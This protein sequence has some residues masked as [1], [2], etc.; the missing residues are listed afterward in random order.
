MFG[1]GRDSNDDYLV[2][3]EI[4]ARINQLDILQYYL[5]YSTLPV[6]ISSP[7]RPDK[8][9]SFGLFLNNY[10]GVSYKDH[11]TFD[12][13]DLF[14]L[15]GKIW[16]IP[17]K[18]VLK[19][20]TQDIPEIKKLGSPLIINKFGAS[21]R[22]KS[23]LHPD[24]D[25]KVKVREWKQHDIDYWEQYGISL[26]WLKKS[27][28]YPISN[29]I[30]VGEGV[31]V[32]LAADKYAYVYV[33]FKDNKPSLKIYQPYNSKYKW[34]NKHDHSVWDLWQ[35]LPKTGDKLII[36]SSRKDA[37]CIWENT[38][39]PAVS[40]QAESY[41][42]KEQVINQLKSRFKDIYIFYD[43]DL[44]GEKNWGQIA[45]LKLAEMFQ[46]TNICVPGGWDAKD[47]SDVA[48][49]WGRNKVT[50]LINTLIK[51]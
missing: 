20:I 25:L 46:L 6:L 38:G 3:S 32:I 47:P 15:L 35:L 33:E 29:L 36:T 8:N 23:V 14:Q 50:E 45:G 37:L 31:E 10:G 30:M 7:I 51:N 5:G 21:R 12:S 18:E 13:G 22:G 27:N 4:L 44:K 48:K 34:R 49:K 9:P 2:K 16:N 19:R 42:P 17:F 39:I 11:T 24:I 26:E 28:T 40:L 1:S 43:N 41:M